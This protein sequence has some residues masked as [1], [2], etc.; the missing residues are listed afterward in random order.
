MQEKKIESI[1]KAY[2]KKVVKQAG[3]WG[4]N[5]IVDQDGYG[6]VTSR[7][8]YEFKV[9]T[10]HRA[11][12]FLHN[13]EIP[14]NKIIRHTCDNRLCTNPEHLVLGTLKDNSADMKAKKRQAFGSKNGN[15]KL[16]EIEVIVIKRLL[17]KGKSQPLIAELFDVN[18]DAISNIKRGLTWFHVET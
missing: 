17:Q 7:Y 9:Q 2:E 18:K 1:R 5:G 10:A 8:I 15:A 11:S 14:R 16:S 6:R 12:W 4:W 13:G 3:C